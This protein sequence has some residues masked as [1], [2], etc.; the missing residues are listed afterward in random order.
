MSKE[1]FEQAASRLEEIVRQMERGDLPLDDALALFEE[2]TKLARI[3]AQK[4]REAEQRVVKLGRDSDGVI[5][6]LP[7]EEGQDE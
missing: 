6:E 7:F 3:C 4:L 5:A 2:G 1:S